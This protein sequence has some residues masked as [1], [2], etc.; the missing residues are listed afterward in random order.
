ML[1]Y[2]AHT[3]YILSQFRCWSWAQIQHLRTIF[4]PAKSFTLRVTIWI[5]CHMKYVRPCSIPLHHVRVRACA[6]SRTACWLRKWAGN[7]AQKYALPL[8][9][10]RRTPRARPV[11]IFKGFNV[12]GV[13]L[14]VVDDVAFDIMYN[15][16]YYTFETHNI[17]YIQI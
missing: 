17:F 5:V 7:W 10:C 13:Y 8:D 2:N 11:K 3:F 12:N 1:C 6:C 15:N 4:K 16:A 14:Y 9:E